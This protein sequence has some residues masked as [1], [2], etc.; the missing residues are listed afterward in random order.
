MGKFNKECKRINKQ[1]CLNGSMRFDVSNEGRLHYKELMI[2]SLFSYE[3]TIKF[4]YENRLQS[5]LL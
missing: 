3:N 4:Q 1:H 5:R 2:F